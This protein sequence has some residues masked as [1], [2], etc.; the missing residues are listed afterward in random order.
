MPG[1]VSVD[2]DADPKFKKEQ[3]ELAVAAAVA[4]VV[5]ASPLVYAATAVV[6]VLAVLVAESGCGGCEV[7]LVPFALV[8]AAEAAPFNS[9]PPNIMDATHKRRSAKSIYRARANANP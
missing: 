3:V 5:D 4:A 1:I 8:L 6:E 9:K 7:V 2:E